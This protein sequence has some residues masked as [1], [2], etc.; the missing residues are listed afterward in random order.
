MS[1]W[2]PSHPPVPAVRRRLLRSLV[3]AAAVAS[4]ALAPVALSGAV[5]SADGGAGATVEGQLVKAWAEA[6]PADP[7]HG[8]EE[9]DDDGLLAWVQPAEG[10][11][12]RIDSAAVDGVPSG[13]SVEVT[14][15]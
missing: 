10:D 11:P 13:S 5:A 8:A 7:D 15:G 12:V 1:G 14:V 6:E 9:H 2:M 3:V 4:G